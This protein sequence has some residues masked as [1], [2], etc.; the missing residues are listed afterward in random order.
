MD[1]AL[2]KAKEDLR[3]TETFILNESDR[4]IFFAAL[5]SPGAPNDALRKL[6][7]ERPKE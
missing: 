2:Q 7:S 4:D 3:E 5:S 6:F 1:S